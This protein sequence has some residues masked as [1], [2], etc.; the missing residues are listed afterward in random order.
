MLVFTWCVKTDTWCVKTDRMHV[1]RT[2]GMAVNPDGT[3]AR[4]RCHYFLPLLQV[5]VHTLLR[6]V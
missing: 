5:L 2:L 6:L 4:I 1:D 3:A